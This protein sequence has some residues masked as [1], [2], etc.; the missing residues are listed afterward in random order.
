M[1]SA[2][3]NGFSSYPLW[4]ANYGVTCPTMPSN[5][6]HWKFWQSSSTG[7]VSGSAAASTWTSSTARS[8]I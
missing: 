5:W 7:T 2:I 3:G 4:V 6:A 1:S 8:P